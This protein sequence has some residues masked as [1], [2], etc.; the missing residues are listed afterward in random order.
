MA[1]DQ[2]FAPVAESG[3]FD[4]ATVAIVVKRYREIGLAGE[5]GGPIRPFDDAA[6]IIQF[7]PA[8]VAQLIL[9]RNAI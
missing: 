7:V 5:A 9:I 2:A 4:P 1:F 6:A 8:Q 3:D